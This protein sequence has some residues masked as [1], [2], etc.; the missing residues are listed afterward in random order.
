MPLPALA[1]DADPELR[2]SEVEIG[3]PLSGFRV[4]DR[5]LVDHVDV[6][7][8]ED[9]LREALEPAPGEPPVDALVQEVEHH[10]RALDP[11][12]APCVRDLP[13]PHR[14]RAIAEE[15]VQCTCDVI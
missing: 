3:E 5:V 9:T 7:T 11:S 6:T 2:Q 8:S 13:D 4:E 1:L 14:R 15:T 10:R 12:T